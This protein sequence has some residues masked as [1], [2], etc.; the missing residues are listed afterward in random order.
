MKFKDLP[1][2]VQAIAASLLKDLY[3]FDQQDVNEER[4]KN[5]SKAFVALYQDTAAVSSDIATETGKLIK[6]SMGVYSAHLGE[7]AKNEMHSRRLKMLQVM[8]VLDKRIS[9]TL[10]ENGIPG[11]YSLDAVRLLLA[12]YEATNSVMPGHYEDADSDF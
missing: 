4:A 8:P 3:I 1:V 6:D 12:V 5:L 7:S 10:E 11:F 9:E 2:E